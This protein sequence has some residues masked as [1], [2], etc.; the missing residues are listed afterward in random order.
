MAELD[1]KALIELS[2]LAAHRACA[3]VGTVTQLVETEK[4]AFMVL[5]AAASHL[6]GHAATLMQEGM[7]EQNGTD[8]GFGRCFAAVTKYIREVGADLPDSAAEVARKRTY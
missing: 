5:I 4:Q 1:D 3:A 8:P 7:S 2:L 6:A